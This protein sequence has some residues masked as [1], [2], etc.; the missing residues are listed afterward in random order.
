MSWE[1]FRATRS[2]DRSARAWIYAAALIL[3]TGI[4]PIPASAQTPSPAPVGSEY[5][6]TTQS[7]RSEIARLREDFQRA[8]N[9]A[10]RDSLVD[11]ASLRLRIW[12]CD[13]IFPLWYGTEWDYNGTTQTPGVGTIACG[14]FVTTCLR[15]VGF[16]LPRVRLSQEPSERIIASFVSRPLRRRWSDASLER[17]VAE[18]AAMG[19]GLY[20]VGLD[21]H[22]GFLI[23]EAGT[24]DFCHASYTPPS[25]VIRESALTS[26]VLAIS[27]YRVVGRLLPNEALVRRWLRDE[28]F[29]VED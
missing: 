23:V 22:V 11:V 18:V 12:L 28:R 16:S 10:A 4:V 24:V 6:L 29:G 27:R 14:Y 17:F 8:R 1:L 19:D 2:A 9:A 15:D 13:S 3:L 25:M 7:I 20:M 21:C 26:S 5:T